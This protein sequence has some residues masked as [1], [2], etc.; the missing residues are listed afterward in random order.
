MKTAKVTLAA[1]NEAIQKKHPKIV[2]ER[3]EGHFYVASDDPEMGLFLASLYTTS[4]HV[5]AIWHLTV[6]QWIEE[7]EKILADEEN[8]SK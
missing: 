5:Y 3:G 1:V 8:S 4:I 7:V 6:E 2:L